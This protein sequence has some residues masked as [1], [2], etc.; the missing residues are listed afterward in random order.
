[1]G[2]LKAIVMAHIPT[3][4]A[5]GSV[6]WEYLLLVENG[7]LERV[8]QAV[9]DGWIQ[10]AQE[11]R[12]GAASIELKIGSDVVV[13]STGKKGLIVALTGQKALVLMDDMTRQEI[14]LSDLQGPG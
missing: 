3:A 6:T 11:A 9:V 7:A 8:P 14:D 13:K 4:Q 10:E 5:D 12:A 2:Q 1:M